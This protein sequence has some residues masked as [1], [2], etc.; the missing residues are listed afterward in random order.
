[1]D[2]IFKVL[3]IGDAGVGKSSILLQFTDGSFN[4]N[5]Q[6]TIGVDFKI[7][8]LSVESQGQMKKVK[9]TIWDTA[10]QERFRTLT[11]SY[12]RGAQGIVVVFDV[13]RPETFANLGSWLG[14]IN[15]FSLGGGRDVVKVLVGNKIDQ[16]VKVKPQMAEA[17]AQGQGMIYMSA[18]A[19]TK[20]GIKDLF[21]EVIAKILEKPELLVNT[22]PNSRASD[23]SN[24]TPNTSSKGC[25]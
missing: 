1:M 17:W 2:H 7:K 3:L 13:T 25:C 9:V 11:N 19:K 10:G 6:S 20:Q 22:K 21:Y 5:L 16:P 24:P 12:Y 8:T 15:Q 14:E 23:I 18:S 4:E